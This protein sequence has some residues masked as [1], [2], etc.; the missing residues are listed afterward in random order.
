MAIKVNLP[1]IPILESVSLAD[2]VLV[3]SSVAHG[4]VA[5][6]VSLQ[7][8]QAAIGAGGGSATING[9]DGNIYTL[10]GRVV[11]GTVAIGAVQVLTGSTAAGAIIQG[12][13]SH[14]YR[15]S[16]VVVD[17]AITIKAALVS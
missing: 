6:L 2:Q 14:Q 3:G 7:S 15:L 4:G 8:I 10:V 9:D 16:G 11:D 5:K 17:G 1:T 12:D 13:D